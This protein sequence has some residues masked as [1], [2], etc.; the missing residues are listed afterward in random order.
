MYDIKHNL[1]IG[2]H[3][4]D[5]SVR[6]MLLLNPNNYKISQK[7]FD[8]LGHGFYFWENN[9]DRALQW[10]IEKKN[11]GGITEPAV[12]GAV[13][14]LG[15]CCDF[16][17]KRFIQHL[18]YY[19]NLMKSRYEPTGRELPQNKDLKQDIHKDKILRHL[20][21]AVIEFM[22]A[23]MLDQVKIIHDAEDG[24]R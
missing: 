19:F 23:E 24:I 17:D 20:D 4:C 10:A 7:P 8:W 1:V 15:Y 6:D 9:Y 13:L 3:G 14:S 16:L 18:T 11:R 12:I 5:R 21:C 22:H 2:F